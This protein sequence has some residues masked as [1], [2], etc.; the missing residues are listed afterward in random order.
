M[1]VKL[2]LGYGSIWILFWQNKKNHKDFFLRKKK[3]D[4]KNMVKNKLMADFFSPN[5]YTSV[6]PK[7][8]LF[9]KL[10]S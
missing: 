5:E 3:V 10:S 8:F 9:F 7:Q 6:K 4:L 2:L 1:R